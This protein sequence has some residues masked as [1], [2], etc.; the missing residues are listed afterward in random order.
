[1]TS[2]N[3]VTLYTVTVTYPRLFPIWAFVPGFGGTQTISAATLLKNQP[4]A[5]QSTTTA[6]AVCT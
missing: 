6:V 1:M 3:A 5:T 2:A 4:Y